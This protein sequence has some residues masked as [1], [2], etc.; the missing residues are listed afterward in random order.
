[1]CTIRTLIYK[2][3]YMP[4]TGNVGKDEDGRMKDE[5]KSKVK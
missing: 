5:S 1:M 2:E 4:Q 3:L